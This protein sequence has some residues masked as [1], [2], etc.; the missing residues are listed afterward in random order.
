MREKTKMKKQNL[1]FFSLI[2]LS[3]FL[4][5]LP[6]SINAAPQQNYEVKIDRKIFISDWGLVAVNDTIK[7]TNIG[8]EDLKS[9]NVGFPS[10]YASNL[11]Y[12]I[13]NFQGEA[14]NIEV[15]L[16]EAR[17]I[18]WLTYIFPQALKPKETYCFS[19]LTV[20]AGLIHFQQG[21]YTY[22]F[23]EAPALE[24][25]AD[26]CNVTIVFPSDASIFL[27]ENSTFKKTGEKPIINHE[28]TPLKS[29][30]TQSLSLNFSSVTI[31]LLDVS[32][33]ERVISLGEFNKI[34]VSDAF[35]IHN[36]SILITAVKVRLPKEA[37]RIM[38]YDYA[39]PLW[40]DER[41]GDEASISPRF[42]DIRQNENFTFKLTYELNSKD[43]IKQVDWRGIYIFNFNFSSKQPWLIENLTVKVVLPKGCEIQELNIKPQKIIESAHQNIL[44][45]N[46]NDVTPLHDLKFTLKYKYS[47]LY[48]SIKPLQWILIIEAVI[49]VFAV[50]ARG[51][52][53][54]P[55][56]TA[57]PVEIISKFVE[58]YDEKMLHEKELSE[59][60]EPE[61]KKALPKKEYKRRRKAAEERLIEI[62][63]A[64]IEL[65]NELKKAGSRYEEL[66]KG[67]EK[68]EAEIEAAKASKAQI[69]LQYRSGKISKEAYES[70]IEDINKRINKA[71]AAIEN[72]LITL[73]EEI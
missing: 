37:T 21:G 29:Y 47:S 11:K 39:G 23:A 33:A 13:A 16:D 67:I 17:E 60:E 4:V 35:T 44:V 73:R 48:A 65:K 6:L 45:Y 36:P 2:L 34:K 32:W 31:Q 62:N 70:I 46:F 53:I 68:A 42:G 28:F 7:I 40:S 20:F 49:F 41:S 3:L 9:V 5:Y 12:Y 71:K 25:Q 58:L 38:A 14:L 69:N 55:T 63:K 19:S 18:C 10:F 24:K 72:A 52:K 26:L 59:V 8:V 30:Y 43:F 54:T 27:P 22:S 66:I 51:K 15:N 1:K 50:I 57:A 64:L 56:V 61:L